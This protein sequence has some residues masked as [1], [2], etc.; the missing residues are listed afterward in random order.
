MEGQIS[1]QTTRDQNMSLDQFKQYTAENTTP[2]YYDFI[3]SYGEIEFMPVVASVVDDSVYNSIVNP[4]ISTIQAFNVDSLDQADFCASLKDELRAINNAP[5]SWQSSMSERFDRT[6]VETYQ[7]V[8][9]ALKVEETDKAM[10]MFSFTMT[11][12]SILFLIAS[13]VVLYYKLVNDIDYEREQIK[14][15]NKIGVNRHESEKYIK[16]HTAFIFFTPLVLGGG[17]GL[18]YTYAFFHSLPDR[19]VSQLIIIVLIMYGL[20][21]IYDV[22][23]YLFIHS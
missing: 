11:F 1:A 14:L 18:L 20:F 19:Y 17:I 8:C 23:F 13:S 6:T 5:D 2:I 12:I 21:I 4:E 10:A 7:P 3:D 16:Q 9:K 22:I 15:F